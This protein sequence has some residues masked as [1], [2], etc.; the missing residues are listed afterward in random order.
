MLNLVDLLNK[1]LIMNIYR[2]TQKKFASRKV[3]HCLQFSFDLDQI[4]TTQSQDNE[5][6][7]FKILS[8][9]Y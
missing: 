1:H 5:W 8:I 9:Y 6:E 3:Q 2:V 4:L 7:I